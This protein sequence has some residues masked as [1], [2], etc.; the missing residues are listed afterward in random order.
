VT[1]QAEARAAGQ[2]R[3]SPE[4]REQLTRLRWLWPSYRIECGGSTWSASPSVAPGETV[5]AGDHLDLWEKIK[6]DHDQRDWPVR[7]G[8]W[9]ECM[10]GPPYWVDLADRPRRYRNSG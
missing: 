2:P 4:Q 8:Y 9:V 6:A 7:N 10:S 3:L 5:T 1:D